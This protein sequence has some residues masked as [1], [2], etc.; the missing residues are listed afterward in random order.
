M[1]RLGEKLRILRK[2]QGLTVRQLSDMLDINHSHITKLETGQ[3]I[4]SLKLALKIADFFG[5]SIDQLARDEQELG[6]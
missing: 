6:D 1:D 4:P 3:S 5:V 2:R